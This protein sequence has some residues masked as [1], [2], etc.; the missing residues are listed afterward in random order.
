MIV[1]IPRCAVCERDV[2]SV[3]S[4]D[5]LLSTIY[6][7][8]CH[9]QVQTCVIPAERLRRMT[10][11]AF[12]DAFDGAE[13]LIAYD[14]GTTHGRVGTMPTELFPTTVRSFGTMPAE[15]FPTTVRSFAVPA[16]AL[17]KLGPGTIDPS[18]AA[19][20]HDPDRIPD[21]IASG[22]EG[23]INHGLRPGSCLYA[24]LCNDLRDAFRRADSGTARAMGAIVMHLYNRV[25]AACWGSV[26]K[27]EAWI[28][29]HARELLKQRPLANQ[30][31]DREME[32]RLGHSIAGRC[33]G[34]G[35]DV[36]ASGEAGHIC[37][38]LL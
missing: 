5:D 38:A 8:R 4:E 21:G 22:I 6:T 7:A 37:P 3:A 24:I 1:K 18:E 25:P 15:L 27:V 34:C 14:I 9:G 13:P 31:A 2:V 12:G 36:T 10:G 16:S 23:Y 32:A 33:T 17:G 35:V 26:D 20:H 28:D 11:I 29:R 30:L 19:Q